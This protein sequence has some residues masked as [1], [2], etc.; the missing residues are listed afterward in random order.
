MKIFEEDNI[1]LTPIKNLVAAVTGPSISAMF[2]QDCYV[3]SESYTYTPL[4][5]TA[6][7]SRLES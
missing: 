1:K 6:Y 2:T 5:L 4:I 3:L 7:M